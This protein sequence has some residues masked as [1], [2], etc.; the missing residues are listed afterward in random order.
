MPEVSATTQT[1]LLN[2]RKLL[3]LCALC[4][5]SIVILIMAVGIPMM[6]DSSPYLGIGPSDSLF[7]FGALV[8]TP[9][10]YTAL[11]I[12]ISVMRVTETVIGDLGYPIIHFEVYDPN[13]K[14]IDGFERWELI[15]LTILMDV[16]GSVKGLI[17]MVI[18]VTRIDIALISMAFTVSSGA[19]A[20]IYLLSKKTVTRKHVSPKHTSNHSGTSN[21]R[22]WSFFPFAWTR[23][24]KN[25]EED[26]FV[27]NTDSDS[28]V[29]P[30]RDLHDL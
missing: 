15:F 14:I 25:N 29:E 3:W 22:N 9:I 12:L 28:D 27:L 17:M 13:R 1:S 30:I 24:S 2:K 16:S 19:C 18:A 10:R 11:I 26:K 23:K 21:A 5:L 6:N 20:Q 7:V 8:N 4:N